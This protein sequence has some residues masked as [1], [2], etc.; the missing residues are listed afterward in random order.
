[1][2]G[3]VN[4]WAIAFIALAVLVLVYSLSSLQIDLGDLKSGYATE[5]G[6][7]GGDLAWLACRHGVPG[8]PDD[9]VYLGVTRE[10][11]A[12]NVSY[13][14]DLISINVTFVKDYPP[15]VSF[16]SP[17]NG[18]TID[19]SNPGAVEF[20]WYKCDP[21]GDIAGITLYEDGNELYNCQ[22][23]TTASIPCDNLTAGTNTYTL[24][25]VDRAGNQYET[26]VILTI[27]K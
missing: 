7:W 18:T 12:T 14:D 20:S 16:N 13:S 5:L 26:S 19:C 21:D 17:K 6:R 11:D 24:R 10:G 23:C 3:F 22:S 25:A 2:K 15:Y 4:S 27:E 8:L 9:A 1:M